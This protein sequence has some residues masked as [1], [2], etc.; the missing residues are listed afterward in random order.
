VLFRAGRCRLAGIEA[1]PLLQGVDRGLHAPRSK[2]A[3]KISS[4][5]SPCQFSNVLA[6]NGAAVG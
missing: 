4:N 1:E 6:G 2:V 3:W 5:H